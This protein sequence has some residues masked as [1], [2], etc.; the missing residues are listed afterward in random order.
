MEDAVPFIGK[1][2]NIFPCAE[3]N[4]V[5]YDAQ[6]I[7]C[8]AIIEAIS[9]VY[10]GYVIILNGFNRRNCIASFRR[11]NLRMRFLSSEYLL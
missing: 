5:R 4:I 9:D 6:V 8:R 7:A 3:N 2:G 11:G 1:V 10:T